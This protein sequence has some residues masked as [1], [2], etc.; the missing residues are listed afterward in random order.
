MKKQRLCEVHPLKKYTV[1]KYPSYGDPDPTRFP[2]LVPFPFRKEMVAVLAGAGMVAV[3]LCVADANPFR[4]DAETSGLPYR[5]SPYGTGRPSYIQEQVAREVVERVFSKEGFKLQRNYQYDRDGVAFV[6]DGY[7]PK[8]GAGYVLG[9]N[10]SLDDDAVIRWWVRDSQPAVADM[11]M[12][13]IKEKLQR[14]KWSLPQQL[15]DEAGRIAQM[16]DVE[17]TREAF[18]ALMEKERNQKLSLA[19]AR[20]LEKRAVRDKEFIAVISR[21]DRRFITSF[22]GRSRTPE[23]KAE[24]DSVAAIKDDKERLEA[25]RKLLERSVKRALEALETSVRQYIRWARSQ[26]LQ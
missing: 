5:T 22:R 11:S 19:E 12:D 2:E 17:E 20:E 18:A 10:K 4:T 9:T 26:G 14:E 21:F 13:E 8:A 7:N 23:E 16:T 3:T 25:F 24:Y 1:A 6:A 15:Q